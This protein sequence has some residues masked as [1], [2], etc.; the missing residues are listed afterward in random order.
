[1]HKNTDDRR[2]KRSRRLLKEGLLTLMQEKKFKDI[3]ARDITE[4]ADLNRGTFYLHYPDTQALLDS[5]E[6]DIMAEAQQL[7]D[8]HLKDLGDGNSLEPVLLP[9]LD[10]IEEKHK[11]IQLLLRNSNASSFLDKLHDL[12]YK[13]SLGYAKARFG[14]RDEAKLNYFLSYASFGIMGMVMEWAGQ[15]MTLPKEKLI[16]YADDLVDRSAQAIF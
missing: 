8:L 13:N 2:A 12:I 16:A 9:I 4:S 6:D 14:I 11:T 1:M 7:V 15:G 3:S 10:Y 5:I